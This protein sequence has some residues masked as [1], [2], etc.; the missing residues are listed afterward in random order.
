MV[1]TFNQTCPYAPL[2]II[3]LHLGLGLFSFT[4][5]TWST[6]RGDTAQILGTGAG[7]ALG[8]HL[9]RRLG[10]LPDPSQW[11]LPFSP[12][13]F[14]AAL[15]ARIV[16]RLLLGVVVLLA[17]RAAMKVVTIPVICRLVGVPSHDVR[18][19]RQHMEVELPY[20]YIVYSTV[21]FNCFFLV[22]F[23]FSYVGLS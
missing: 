7:I 21:G 1:D 8:A 13:P 4:L 23:L 2:A 11:Q 9:N 18:Q 10:L 22:P 19:A 16:L 3:S 15:L 5:D 6:S 17:T 20:R 14:S 12:P